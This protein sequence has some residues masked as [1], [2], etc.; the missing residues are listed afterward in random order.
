LFSMVSR[1]FS[2][3][4][5][6]VAILLSLLACEAPVGQATRILKIEPENQTHAPNQ[7]RIIP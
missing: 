5:S 1:K 3:L 7:P 4:R 2:G 6:W